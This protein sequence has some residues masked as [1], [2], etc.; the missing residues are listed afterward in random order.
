MD[1]HLIGEGRHEK[2]WRVLGAHRRA[3]TRRSD[4]HVLRGLGAQRARR[5]GRRR[6]QL[7]GRPA[8]TRCARSGSSGVWEL[9]VPDVPAGARYKF[10]VLGA[11][12]VWRQKADPLAR[13][14]E[15]PPATASVV[16]ESAYDWSDASW[17]DRRAHTALHAAPMS[18]YEVHLGSWRQGLSYRE[19][20]DQLVELRAGHGLHPR[21]VPAGRRAPVRRVLG[22][23][24]HVLLRADVAVRQPGRVPLPRR[25][26]APGRHRRDRR[27]GAGALPE[28]RV[29]AGAL[30]RHAALRA[31]RPAA[32]RAA[33]LGHVRLRL[34]PQRGAQLPRRQRAVL[35][36]GVP[37]RRAAR[38]RGGLDAL[39]GLLPQGRRVG[40]EPVRRPGEP[41]RGVVPA[42]DERHGLPRAPGRHDR[43]PR[44]PPR[45]RASRGRRTSAGSASASSGTWAGCTTPWTTCRRSRSTA[46]T[47]TTR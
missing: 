3:T 43:S 23:P 24:G 15:H 35:A 7:L 42:G 29:G 25:P 34:R 36:R 32:R 28:G 8:A 38:R 5:A 18:V 45:G 12:S 44:S 11:D 17:L 21:G 26:A 31:R 10:E 14:T 22:L 16:Y 1:L 13:H 39:P 6:L 19:L 4:R 46:A 41:R 20:A 40:P 2:L 37:H 47:T 9:F 30:R 33:G 27:L